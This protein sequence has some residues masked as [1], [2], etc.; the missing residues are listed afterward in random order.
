MV[1]M[2]VNAAARTAR[3]VTAIAVPSFT[4]P[5]SHD[6]G[7]DDIRWAE[8]WKDWGDRGAIA[9]ALGMG[10]PV[11]RTTSPRPHFDGSGSTP[12]PVSQTVSRTKYMHS[13]V[14]GVM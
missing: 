12:M 13:C 4:Q 9:I 6:S 3:M 14:H 1:L 11:P 10:C 2:I 7:R 5:R 8:I